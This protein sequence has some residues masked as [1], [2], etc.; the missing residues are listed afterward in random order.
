MK[1][2]NDYQEDKNRLERDFELEGECVPLI[3]QRFSRG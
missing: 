1:K 3:D 2:R